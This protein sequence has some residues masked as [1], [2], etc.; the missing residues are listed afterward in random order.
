MFS[1]QKLEVRDFTAQFVNGSF[2]ADSSDNLAHSPVAPRGQRRTYSRHDLKQH[3]RRNVR[4]RGGRAN[5]FAVATSSPGA[6]AASRGPSRKNRP[7]DSA[8]ARPR[9]SGA[10]AFAARP[11]PARVGH[12]PAPPTANTARKPNQPRACS[13]RNL[14]MF[15]ARLATVGKLDPGFLESLL[16]GFSGRSGGLVLVAFP[17]VQRSSIDARSGCKVVKSPSQ[18]GPSTSYML[19][20]DANIFRFLL[21]G[22]A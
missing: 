16:N 21:H 1:I 3:G 2:L 4:P 15:Y 12:L 22:S 8:A 19:V 7:P 6:C 13:H 14:S 11:S 17:S 18:H 5:W 9:S 10:T 20:D